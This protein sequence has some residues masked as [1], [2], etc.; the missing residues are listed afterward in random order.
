LNDAIE[1]S[2][3]QPTEA[4]SD[5]Q[6]VQDRIANNQRALNDAKDVQTQF[7]AFLEGRQN[8]IEMADK[9]EA[10]VRL[11]TDSQTLELSYATLS[12]ISQLS[13]LNYL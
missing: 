6:S 5:L 11:Q 8:E 1:H 7:M 13:L 3:L 12:K 9:T 10:A 2:S 4:P